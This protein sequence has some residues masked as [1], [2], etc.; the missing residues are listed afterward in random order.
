M[1]KSKKDLQREIKI[2]EQQIN[3]L[4]EDKINLTRRNSILLKELRI[5]EN[6]LLEQEDVIA[7][8]SALAAIGYKKS[9]K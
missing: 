3:N 9:A 7:L 5:L 6:K 4:I 1:W 2:Q 8:V